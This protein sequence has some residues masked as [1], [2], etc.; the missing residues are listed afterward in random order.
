ME[1]SKVDQLE[2]WELLLPK[3]DAVVVFEKIKEGARGGIDA[4]F[5]TNTNEPF[6][7]VRIIEGASGLD[8]IGPLLDFGRRLGG[9][10]FV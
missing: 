9:A 8:S 10:V 5:R 4:S 6:F 2:R 3:A 1:N 7:H